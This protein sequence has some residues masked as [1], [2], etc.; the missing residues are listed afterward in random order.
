M[1]IPRSSLARLL[2]VMVFFVG[3]RLPVMYRQ[4]GGEDEE[5]YAVPGYTVATEGIPRVPYVPARDRDAWFYRVDDALF[6][7]PPAYFYWQGPFFLA[8]PAGYGTAR[9]AS[10]AAGLMAVWLVYELGR[11]LLHDEAVGL[12]AAALYSLSRVFFF[13]AIRARPDILCGMLGLAAL[14]LTWNW[15]SSGNLRPLMLAGACLGLGM[16][17]HPFALAYCLQIGGWVVVAANRRKQRLAAPALLTGC[18][19]AAFA[20]WIPLILSWPELFRE[21]FVKNVLNQA[22]PGL[23]RRILLPW[24]SL[25][26]HYHLLLEHVQLLQLATMSLGLIA[27]TWLALVRRDAGARLLVGLAWSGVYLLVTVQGEHPAKGYW[28]YPGALVWLCTAYAAVTLTRML[29]ARARLP[30]L[31]PALAGGILL[32]AMLPGLGARTWLAQMRHWNDVNY[33]APR[34]ARELLDDLPSDARLAVDEAFVFDAYL[35]GRQV[36]LACNN[37]RY[38]ESS[39]LPYDYLIITRLGRQKKVA[40][41]MQGRLLREYGDPNDLFACYAQ[42]YVPATQKE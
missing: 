35:A 13:S 12:A 18:A 33:N 6:A 17:T 15:R 5:F 36:V 27:A 23:A 32:A 2:I 34:F 31:C 37:P 11:R 39:A 25:V 3:L 1:L 19:L 21:Q 38:F 8:L 22:G 28:C 40:A 30:R 9:L 42:V 29:A 14:L 41:S 16:L 26:Y 4:E 10:A 20:L 24:P 7:L